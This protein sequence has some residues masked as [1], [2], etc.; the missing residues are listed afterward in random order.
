[1]NILSEREYAK[2]SG[3]YRIRNVH[4]NNA[5]IGSSVNLFERQQSHISTLERRIHAN[6]HL[7]NA[8][9]KY[10]M[11]SFVFEVLLFCDK[12]NLIYYEQ[13]CLDNLNSYYN[14]RK[15]AESSLGNKH[16]LKARERMSKAQKERFKKAPMSAEHKEKI[17]AGGRGRVVSKKTRENLRKA[18]VGKKLTEEHKRKL[19]MAAKKRH[20]RDRENGVLVNQHNR[21]TKAS[22]ETKEKMRNSQRERRGKEKLNGIPHPLLGKTHSE[23]TKAKMR[24]TWKRKREER[25]KRNDKEY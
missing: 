1:M 3:I 22:E 24:A 9:N 4:D 21:G 2:K 8:W 13:T 25:E 23:E 10:G 17:G 12:K 5:Y 15:I 7:Q 19:S 14:I 16:S 6:S 11:H 18:N 20:L